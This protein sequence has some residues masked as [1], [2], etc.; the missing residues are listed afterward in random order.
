MV[1]LSK[2]DA[3]IDEIKKSIE[4]ITSSEARKMAVSL[5]SQIE[6]SYL[7]LAGVLYAIK[8]HRWLKNYGYEKFGDFVSQEVN[9]PV[10]R[11]DILVGIYEHF[12]V[13]AKF[14]RRVLRGIAEIG[15]SKA[16]DLVGVATPENAEKM[17]ELAKKTSTDA[18][19]KARSEGLD[20][21]VFTSVFAFRSRDE[22][23][24]VEDAVDTLMRSGQADRKGQA[25]SQ[26][27]RAFTTISQSMDRAS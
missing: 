6:L 21:D 27:C 4:T 13:K 23:K 20:R 3:Q 5:K 9:L 25:L 14:H 7:K 22:Q 12:V 8:S 16:K 2:V 17:I 19:P 18:R 15:F 11:G 26:I 10:H 24:T 1:K